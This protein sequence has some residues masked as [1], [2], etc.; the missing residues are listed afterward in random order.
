MSD[1]GKQ[2]DQDDNFEQRL[3]Q[4]LAL[5]ERASDQNGPQPQRW[6]GW[7]G[8]NSALTR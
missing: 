5:I 1:N 7:T 8:W 4:T 3:Y 6:S 2:Y